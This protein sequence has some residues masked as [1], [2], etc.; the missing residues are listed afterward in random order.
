MFFLCLT[1]VLAEKYICNR[2]HNNSSKSY[3]KVIYINVEHSMF[4]PLLGHHQVYLSL[5]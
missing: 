3:N 1:Y 2:Q 5:H 4:R